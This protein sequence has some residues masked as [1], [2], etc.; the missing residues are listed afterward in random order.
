MR[1]LPVPWTAAGRAQLRDDFAELL[2]LIG[3]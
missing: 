2:K 3:C 1:L